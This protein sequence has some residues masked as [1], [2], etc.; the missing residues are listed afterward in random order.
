MSRTPSAEPE[1]TL[2]VI[3][4]VYNE[5]PTIAALLEK[6]LRAP[7][8]KEILVVDD[9]STDGTPEI[10]GRFN[11]R[12]GV[13]VLRQERNRGKGAALRR[14]IPET[15]G[16]IVVF[17]DADLE[18]DPED[19]PRLTEPIL[20]YGADAV[21]GSRFIGP[22]RVFLFWHYAVNRFLTLL[23]NI[24]FDTNLTDMETG[25]K[26]FRGAALRALR[27]RAVR[28][29]IEPEITARLFQGG[30]RVFEVPVAYSGR[31]YEEGKKI[32]WRDALHA[33]LTLIRCRLTRG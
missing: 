16:E 31:S 24:L 29:E 20:R 1:L 19:Y 26:A 28:F 25:S 10:L 9:G 32:G 7:Y 14:A 23:T 21:Y 3:V 6:V 2:S 33:L 8:R 13:R 12:D 17:Q 11:G 27:L 15:R 4:P 30:F 5:A 18:Y 22:H